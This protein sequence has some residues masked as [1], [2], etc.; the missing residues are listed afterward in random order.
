MLR[1]SDRGCSWQR[2]DMPI[3]MGGNEDGRSNG[4]RL[5]VDPHQPSIVLFGS[6]KDGLWKS[7]DAAVT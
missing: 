4:E 1:S 5:A 6:R 2:T 7:T 3:Q